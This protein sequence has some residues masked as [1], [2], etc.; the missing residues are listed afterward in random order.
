MMPGLIISLFLFLCAAEEPGNYPIEPVPFTDVTFDDAFWKPR[1]ERNRTVTV[2]Y[3]FKKCEE[4]GRIDNFAKAG[5]LIDGDFE[6]IFFNDSDVFKVVEGASYSLA[7]HPDAELDAYLDALIAKFAAAQ[8]EDGYLYTVRTIDPEKTPA[9]S[10]KTRWS[11]LRVGHELYNVG[12]MYEAAA[13]HFRATGKRNFLDVA[14]RNADLV[15]S[16]F[17][18]EKKRDIPGHQEIEIGLCRLY[19]VTGEKKYLDLAKFFLDERGRAHGRSLYGPYCQDHLPVTEQTEAVGHAVRA[20]YMYSGMADVAAL[21]G[22][23]SYVDAIDRI[24]RNVVER[25]LYIT[26][27]IGA[28]HAGEAFGDDFELP[29]GTAYNETCA[30]I[31]N[32]MWNHRLFLLHGDGK[33]IDVLE[34]I[35]YNGFLSGVSLSADAF[36]YPNP[37]SSAGKEKRSP[38]FGCSCCPTN[39]VRFLP[40]LPGYACARRGDCIFVNLYVGG[41]ALV[42]CDGRPVRLVTKTRYPWEGAVKITVET[43]SPAPFEIRLRIPG[44]ARNIPAPGGLY[45]YAG[46]LPEKPT[47]SVNG[48]PVP[49]VVEKG[50]APIRRTWRK[51]DVITL[52]LPMPIRRVLCD[53]RVAANRGRVALERGP[54][55]FCAEWP[56]NQGRTRNIVLHDEAPLAAVHRPDLLGGVTV[57]EGTARVIL[58]DADS[59]DRVVREQPFTAI[60][61]HVWAHRGTGEMAVWLPTDESLARPLKPPTIASKSRATASHTWSSDTTSALNDRLEPSSS[62]DHAIPRHSWWNHQGSTE[63]VRY[64]FAGETTISAVAVYWFDDTGRGSCRV[65]QSWRIFYR[66]GDGWKPVQAAD[67]RTTARD[68]YNRVSFTPVTTTAL[69]IDVTLQK[70]FSGGILEWIVE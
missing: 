11:N 43:K 40:S 54:I 58:F 9:A 13:A 61:Y 18:P 42:E 66:D 60:P 69:K 21:T 22:D 59:G 38:W 3:D 56:D 48:K 29:N 68:R 37:L 6:G 52:N 2:P 12:H 24:W 32:A 23:G 57:L 63:W 55:V 65:P 35:I 7:L 20:G 30:A 39:V 36:F 17:G 4:T 27:G 44:W 16:L 53:R 26:G 8:E 70:N 47:L 62:G 49:L 33:Y 5:G 25:K 45:T 50:F 19:L 67:P 28:R 15:A 51:G 31:A 34:R 14:L 46:P 64:D 10:G 1:L 41:T